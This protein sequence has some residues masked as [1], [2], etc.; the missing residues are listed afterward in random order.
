MYPHYFHA[1]VK[2]SLQLLVFSVVWVYLLENQQRKY[3]LWEIN[4]FPFW[5]Y[6]SQPV[7]C[8]KDKLL[9]NVIKLILFLFAVIDFCLTRTLFCDEETNYQSL[10][11]CWASKTNCYQRRGKVAVGKG[12][13]FDE[14]FCIIF[15]S[16]Y[17][18]KSTDNF[19]HEW[20]IQ[21][22]A[23]LSSQVLNSD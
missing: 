12:K 23:S 2:I 6:R 18:V 5:L 8:C 3:C 22:C 9:L 19:C 21:K 10:R 15:Q 20:F 7:Y 13:E 16:V 4:F 14:E 1:Y 11:L 17:S